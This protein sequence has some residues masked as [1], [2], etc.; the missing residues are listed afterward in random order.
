MYIIIV[1]GGNVGYYL[2]KRLIQ[3]KH[4]VGII[5]KDRTLCEKIA[6]ELNVLAIHGDGCD[7]RFLEDAGI[8]RAD[9]VAAVTGDDEDNLVICQLA[10]ETFN[11][12]RTVAR[13]ND[14]RNEHAFNELGVDVPIDSTAIIA[15]IIEE[16][17]SFKDFV[18]LM[19]FKRGKLAIVRV[20]LTAESPI[21]NK[22]VMDIKLP[23]DS[24]LVS[25]IRGEDV[26]IPKGTTVLQKRDDIIALTTIENEQQLLDAL[27]GKLE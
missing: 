6:K 24:V 25:I 11:I 2:A 22:Q 9:V 21:C 5:E 13:V 7:P 19:T 8:Q 3:N 17:V 23:G 10:K 27:I 18:N 1:G 12:R 4:A 16:E 20:D 26:I 15:K 14:S